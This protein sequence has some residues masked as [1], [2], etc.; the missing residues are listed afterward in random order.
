M[1][2]GGVLDLEPSLDDGLAYLRE[3]GLIVKDLPVRIANPIYREVVVQ[4]LG[5]AAEANIIADPQS[6]VLPDGRLDFDLMLREFADFWCEHAGTLSR[7]TAYQKSASYLAIMAFLQ[8]VVDDRGSVSREYGLYRGRVDLLIRWPYV[9]GDEQVVQREAIE[10]D[11]GGAITD[12]SNRTGH[13]TCSATLIDPEA[14]V[15]LIHHNALGLWLRP[16]GHLEPKDTPLP[17]AALRER[18]EETGIPAMPGHGRR[19]DHSPR[20]RRPRDPGQPGPGRA[21]ALAFRP[22]LRLPRC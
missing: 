13:L 7:P 18:C 11:R 21:R 14:R 9:D 22:V 20:H 5:T 16:G 1:I 12:R 4:A 8:H 2:A 10:L 6:F 17:Q 3:I 19:R 15:L